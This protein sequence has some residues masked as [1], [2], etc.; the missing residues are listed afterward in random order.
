[1]AG[2]ST[3]LVSVVIPCH[4]HASFLADAVHSVSAQSHKDLEVIVVDDGSPHD[5]AQILAPWPD[6]RLVRQENRG[7]A[8][9]RNAGM[10]A[11]RSR[12]LVF[13]DAD[14]RLRPNAL[15]CGIDVL[16]R[17]REIGATWGR[18]DFITD[19][20]ERTEWV[21]PDGMKLV[22]STPYRGSDPY[23]DLLRYCIVWC[24]ASAFFRRDVVEAVGGFRGVNAVADWD[25]YL[26]VAKRF[27][28]A[29]HD[30]V[31]A[32][33]RRHP[34]NMTNDHASMRDICLDLLRRQR[35]EVR[36]VARYEAALEEGLR[37]NQDYWTA[38]ES[39]A[40]SRPADAQ[41]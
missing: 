6:I 17:D 27:K 28:M 13:L 36:G 24:P 40:V 26:R 9:A 5:L 15:A 23:E 34:G 16:A 32:Q 22:A 14:D 37:L 33:Y 29:P 11:A 35:T 31:V 4:S 10:N 30:H 18:C 7:V 39:Q 25:L 8:A 2:A 21:E 19:R 1:M 12:F 3:H 41:R 38:L 20:G